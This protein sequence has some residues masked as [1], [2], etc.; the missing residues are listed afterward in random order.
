MCLLKHFTSQQTEDL[1]PIMIINERGVKRQMSTQS[2][3]QSSS[4]MEQSKK[5]YNR[6][7]RRPAKEVCVHRAT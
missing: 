7:G 3:P 6:P 2:Y 4:L 5:T 1:I